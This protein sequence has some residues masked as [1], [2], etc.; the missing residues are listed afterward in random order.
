MNNNAIASER[1]VHGAL[2]FAEL[3][4]LGLSP[5]D[6]VDFSV[7]ANPY[8][9]SPHVHK[10][11]ADAVLDRYPDRVCL[12][13]RETILQYELA[14][15]DLVLASVVCG[16][17]ASELIWA[18]ARTFLKPDMKAAIIGPTFGEYRAASQAVGAFVSEMQ[19][20]SEN[21]FRH[22]LDTL[23]AWLYTERPHLV[24]LCNPNNPTGAWLDKNSMF[25]IGEMCCEINAALVVDESYRHFV[26]PRETFSAVDLPQE[27]GASIIILRSLTKDF[28]LAGVRLGYGI[29]S[30]EVIE[31][32]TA[33]LPAWNV[34]SLA[35]AAGN[36]ALADREHLDMTLTTLAH[37]CEAFFT[38]LQQTNL[39]IVPS[40]THFC[41]VEVGDAQRVRQKL[42]LR[43]LLVRD[44]TSFGLPHYIRVATRPAHEWQRLLTS[45]LEVL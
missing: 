17:G 12:Q 13:L 14:E 37:E 29:G 34:S 24:W 19:A 11:I 43:G 21:D 2:D 44:C 28:A 1:A 20:L 40:R 3:A 23:L 38:A 31:R 8:G 9:P 26:W 10:A 16:N 18:A 41:L 36:V 25:L 33:Q 22:N 45:L 39:Y 15:T 7:N 6:I 4:C 30:P 35:Q 42:L 27:E 32:V 5:N